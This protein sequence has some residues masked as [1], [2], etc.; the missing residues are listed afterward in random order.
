MPPRRLT[1]QPIRP[2]LTMADAI[3]RSQSEEI[4]RLRAALQRLADG[5]S[6]RSLSPADILAICEEVEVR[7]QYDGVS[8]EA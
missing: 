5:A 8:D 6:Q 3:E 4:A 2:A 7:P 1:L